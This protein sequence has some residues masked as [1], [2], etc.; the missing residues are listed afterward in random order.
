M[1]RN[2]APHFQ[3]VVIA[4]RDCGSISFA[5]KNEVENH[6]VSYSRTNS[7]ELRR[8]LDQID[9]DIIVSNWHKIIDRD[10]V[11]RY[12]GRM[13]NLHYS[14]LPAFGGLIGT[15]PIVRAYAQGC[16]FIGPTC[17][18]V[19]IDVDSGEIISQAIFPVEMPI[20]EATQLMFRKGCLILLD[21]ILKILGE[22]NIKNGRPSDDP[23]FGPRLCFESSVFTEEFWQVVASA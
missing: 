6:I 2:I 1:K 13:I 20:P 22:A 14:L 4:D 21:S 7:I 8:I 16:K 19:D 18:F 15:E 5:K 12:R 9:P 23:T 17:H 11:E 10:T 3:I